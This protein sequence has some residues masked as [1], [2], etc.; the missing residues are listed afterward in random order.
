MTWLTDLLSI[1]PE[2]CIAL[3]FAPATLEIL[4]LNNI[5]LC[6]LGLIAFCASI[7]SLTS[8]FEAIRMTSSASFNRHIRIHIVSAVVNASATL[9]EKAI[10]A[11]LAISI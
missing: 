3:I 2:S 9:Q 1:W 5:A 11:A 6:I 8:A 7:L 10:L 4:F